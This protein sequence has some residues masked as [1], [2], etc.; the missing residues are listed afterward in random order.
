MNYQELKEILEHSNPSEWLYFDKYGQFTYKKDVNLRIVRSDSEENR[1][2]NESW[3]TKHPDPNATRVFLTVYYNQ[4]IIEEKMMV[5]IDG[6]RA[7][8]P[9]RS[10]TTMT[11]SQA[12]YQLALI[13]NGSL[14]NKLNEY[15]MRSGI[16]VER[17]GPT[18]LNN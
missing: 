16:K 6:Y 18:C 5:D 14:G 11:V 3:A 12:D 15:L 4:S 13:V 10:L 7:T 9:I 17:G 2:F 8:L 1:P